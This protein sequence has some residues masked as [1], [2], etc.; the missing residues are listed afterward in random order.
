[1]K[2]LLK[3]ARESSRLCFW[4]CWLVTCLTEFLS[5]IQTPPAFIVQWC[6]C[7]HHTGLIGVG[8]LFTRSAIGFLTTTEGK[9]S[10]NVTSEIECS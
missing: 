5:R 3:T 10:V 6:Q 1:M 8:T 9:L 7:V 2:N 4:C